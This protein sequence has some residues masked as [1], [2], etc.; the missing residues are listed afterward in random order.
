[1][2]PARIIRIAHPYLWHHPGDLID[3]T[4]PDSGITTDRA[5]QL[6]SAGYAVDV[7]DRIEGPDNGWLTFVTDA[8]EEVK[9]RDLTELLEAITTPPDIRALD[10]P[11]PT[12]EEDLEDLE[13]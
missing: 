10:E 8:G 1:M 13:E 9:A 2:T 4:D 7:T 12:E 11:I 6:I 3:T 5:R